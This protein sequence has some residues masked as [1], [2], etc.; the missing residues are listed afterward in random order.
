MNSN[1]PK[2]NKSGHPRHGSLLA[3]ILEIADAPRCARWS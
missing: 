2:G 3:V 1:H